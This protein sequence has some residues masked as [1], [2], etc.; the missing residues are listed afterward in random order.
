ML[1][2]GTRGTSLATTQQDIVHSWYLTLDLLG[3]RRFL[4]RKMPPPP[5]P[6]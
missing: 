1:E 3:G 2:N 4:V 6:L 5:P